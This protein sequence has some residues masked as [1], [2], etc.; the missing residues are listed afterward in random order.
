MWEMSS[1]FLRAVIFDLDG[2]LADTEPL[3]YASWRE[4]I[5]DAFG[6]TVSW[7]EYCEHWIRRGLGIREYLAKYELVGDAEELWRRKSHRY[8]PLVEAQL[9]PMP[10]ALELLGRLH[11]RVPLALASSSWRTHVDAVLGKLGARHFFDVVATGESV[12]R[13]KPHPDIFLHTAETLGAAPGRCVV[14]EDAEKGVLAAR[15]AGM[16]V[17]AIPTPYSITH[18]LASASRVVQSL[19]AVTLEELD[20]LV[21]GRPRS[22]RQT[23]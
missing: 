22:C 12:A 16:A 20:R 5:Q 14:L 4:V 17:V 11:G 19:E 1:F 2:L 3:H 7:D 21:G 23:Q 8:L 9:R 13:L 18:D 6:V 10:G 15:A